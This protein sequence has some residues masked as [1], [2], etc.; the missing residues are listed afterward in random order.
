[1]HTHTLTGE[2]AGR[3]PV[4]MA[5]LQYHHT[6][7]QEHL[8]EA[9]RPEAVYEAPPD[10]EK[11]VYEAPPTFNGATHDEVP[12]DATYEQISR[13]P[14]ATEPDESGLYRKFVNRHCSCFYNSPHNECFYI[15]NQ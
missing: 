15:S 8:Y 7:S 6:E 12:P 10:K 1:M 5:N 3:G 9:P 13:D 11:A 2:F 14:V 4:T